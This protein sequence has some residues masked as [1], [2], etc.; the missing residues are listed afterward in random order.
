MT[1]EPV[2]LMVAPITVSPARFATG[3][4]SPVIMASSTEVVPSRTTPSTGTFS[5]GRTRRLSPT[6][7]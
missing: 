4:G 5:P 6:S 3:S 1:T 7:T 2:R